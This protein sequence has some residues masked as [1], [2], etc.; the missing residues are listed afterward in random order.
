MR[1]RSLRGDEFPL[2]FDRCVV[3]VGYRANDFKLPGVKEHALFMKE[4]K[5]ATRFREHLLTKL[6][7]ASYAHALGENMEARIRQLCSVVVVGG[8]PTGVE[9]A[10]EITDFVA[11]DLKRLY[12]HLFPFISVHLVEGMPTLLNH[13]QDEGL[14]EYAVSHISKTQGVKLHLQEFVSEATSSELR[15]KSGKVIPYGTLVWCAGV[16]PVPVIEALDLAKTPNGAQLLTDSNMRVQ[17]QQK[18]FAIGDCAQIDGNRLPQTA[19]VAKQQA[20]YLARELNAGEAFRSPFV[21]K[22]LGSMA[23]LGSN[24]GL[25]ADS[26]VVKQIRGHLAWLGWRSA[27]WGMQLTMRNRLALASDWFSTSLFGRPVVRFGQCSVESE[28]PLT[29]AAASARPTLTSAAAIVPGQSRAADLVGKEPSQ[30]S[31][32]PSFQLATLAAMANGVPASARRQESTL[33]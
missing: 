22:S 18:I 31:T 19:Q 23:Y 6:E 1:C 20:Q 7:E 27:Y 32:I 26:P 2:R 25:I 11:C 28:Q 29:L 21:F 5:D 3:A 14:R 13:L 9:L 33:A 12:P 17:G 8:G 4:T 10:A 24:K 30:A 16:K 15:L